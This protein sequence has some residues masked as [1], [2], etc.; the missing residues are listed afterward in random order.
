MKL[1]VNISKRYVFAIIALLVVF[2]VVLG[3]YAYNSNPAN[4]SLFG[5]SANEVEVNIGGTNY[6]LQDAITGGRIGGIGGDIVMRKNDGVLIAM[7]KGYFPFAY[8]VS[9][10]MIFITSE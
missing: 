7:R 10:F 4:P 9:F 3:A 8:N 2:G 6:G 1:E 5:H